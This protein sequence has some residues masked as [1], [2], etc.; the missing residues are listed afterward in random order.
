MRLISLFC[1]KTYV[2][3]QDCPNSDGDFRAEQC[4]E[5]DNQSFRGQKYKWEPYVK[6]E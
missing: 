4:R 6:G 3:L 5:F 2:R 1:W